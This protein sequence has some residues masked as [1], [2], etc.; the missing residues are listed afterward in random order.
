MKLIITGHMQHGKDTVSEILRDDYDMPYESSSRV[1]CRLFLFDQLKD[2][3]GYSDIEECYNDRHHH[4]KEWFDAIVDYNTPHL[5][6]LGDKILSS[7]DIYCG[8]RN[9][10]ELNAIREHGLVDH[11][12]WVDARM[13]KPL[14]PS[15]SLTITPS[16][17][18][19][20]LD[21][22]GSL[23]QLKANLDGLLNILKSA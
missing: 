10:N 11:V 18:D 7:S 15:T 3:Y 4:R 14:E 1:A 9:I 17:C 16:D 13:R 23:D 5:H 21:N 12:I 6:A 22:N 19:W 2:K 20:I 8:L